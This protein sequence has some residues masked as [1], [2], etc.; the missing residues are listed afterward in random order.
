MSERHQKESL[1]MTWVTMQQ[2]VLG[3]WLDLVQGA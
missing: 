2:K 3:G 1:L